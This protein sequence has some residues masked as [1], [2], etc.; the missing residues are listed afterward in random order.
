[1][2]VHIWYNTTHNTTKCLYV[3]IHRQAAFKH[4]ITIH[5]CTH[6]HERRQRCIQAARDPPPTAP[7]QKWLMPARSKICEQV[8]NRDA[9]AIPLLF[10][11]HDKVNYTYPVKKMGYANVKWC[12]KHVPQQWRNRAR[13]RYCSGREWESPTRWSTK[14]HRRCQSKARRR[15]SM[16]PH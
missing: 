11:S 16:A 2:D 5:S 12:F 15:T 10:R 13:G 3:Y 14:G 9:A 8:M 4:T 7:I 6:K 1:M